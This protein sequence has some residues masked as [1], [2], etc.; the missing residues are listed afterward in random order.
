MKEKII[1]ALDVS[2]RDAAMQLVKQ[3]NAVAG[4]FKIGSQLFTAAGPPVVR[5]IVDA[6]G[7]V[8]LDLKFHDIPNTV[9]RAACEAANL[10]VSML[11]IHAA[12]G[13][14]MMQAASAELQ[15]AFGNTR[16]LLIGITVLTSLDARALFEIGVEI[17]VDEQ[18]QRLA[19]FAEACGLDGV[20]CSPR[21]IQQVRQCVKADFKVVTPGIRMPDQALNDQERVATPKEA[22]ASGADYIVI[23]RPVTAA[24]DPKAAAERILQ[25]I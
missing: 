22:L 15:E 19:I 14:A 13:R 5:D 12:G 4:M 16:P 1:I 2:S 17:P 3:L 24:P 25:S 10:G 21:E 6:G 7:K 18:V 9:T 8:F 23:G 11:T 20:V